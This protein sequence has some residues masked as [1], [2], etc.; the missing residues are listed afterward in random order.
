MSS[1][2][3]DV[4]FGE[5][6][7]V[8]TADNCASG[9][10]VTVFHNA[11][12]GRTSANVC[13]AVTTKAVARCCAVAAPPDDQPAP[14]P[15]PTM[16][17]KFGT[18]Y[19]CAELRWKENRNSATQS[20][21][22]GA[23]YCQ[24]RFTDHVKVAADTSDRMTYTEASTMCNSRGA[25]LCSAEELKHDGNSDTMCKQIDERVWT[26]SACNAGAG[27]PGYQGTWTKPNP[28]QSQYQWHSQCT[29]PAAKLYVRCCASQVAAGMMSWDADVNTPAPT[30]QAD[31]V[32]FTAFSPD[33]AIKTVEG[34]LWANGKCPLGK[35]RTADTFTL[36][37][38]SEGLRDPCYSCPWGKYGLQSGETAD[39]TC[40]ECASD[41]Y[42]R[43]FGMGHCYACPAG[44]YS[45]PKRR[46][47]DNTSAVQFS[48]DLN[49]KDAACT[50]GEYADNGQCYPCP[51]GKYAGTKVNMC[52][53]C[54][55]GT[56]QSLSGQFACDACP[57]GKFSS[58][59]NEFCL[60]HD[61]E[62]H[63]GTDVVAVGWK[64]PG[65][66]ENFCN[67][68][69]CTNMGL[70]CSR[71]AC[72][73]TLDKC[74]HVKC[75]L[76]TETRWDGSKIHTI[77]TNHDKHEEYGKNH[78]CQYH[79]FNDDCQCYC[80]GDKK[81][82]PDEDA[83]YEAGSKPSELENADNVNWRYN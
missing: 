50:K 37:R 36:V 16:I 27:T 23:N 7:P 18:F 49:S 58:K 12:A 61:E 60:V 56:Y 71:K 9:K 19:G 44:R 3:C 8:W 28:A 39:G 21:L 64:G 68:C 67:L 11:A 13:S 81:I 31:N 52:D 78:H 41:Q 59:H 57:K 76:K 17:S 82:L 70:T 29:L 42:Q 14:T 25:R 38:A 15:A 62:C 5:D 34:Y 66:G 77:E 63:V 53:Q 33:D 24:G 83:S 75:A 55:G 4:R 26:S 73:T 40:T 20:G 72:S 32:A 6:K 43:Y 74:S 54:P 51:Q 46:V 30:P 69:S 79:L 1:Q 22:C 10:T 2:A 65:F 48:Q 35:Y 47:C 45:D 80:F